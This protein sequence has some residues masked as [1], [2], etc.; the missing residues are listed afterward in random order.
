MEISKPETAFV[1][2]S[3]VLICIGT[4]LGGWA[5]S[6]GHIALLLS[7]GLMLFRR[8]KLPESNRG[9][10][11]VSIGLVRGSM[12]FL[13]VICALDILTIVLFYDHYP[14]PLKDLK[15]IR[16]LLIPLGFL[17][18]TY[19]RDLGRQYLSKFGVLG[20]WLIGGAV[21]LA[22]AS[23][24]IGYYT[25][26][27]PLRFGAE[28]ANFDRLSGIHGMVMTY[29]YSLQFVVLLF[30][31]VLFLGWRKLN[32]Y[33]LVFVAVT[34]GVGVLGL[35][36]SMTRGA[37]L[38]LII[39][40]VALVFAAK[41]WKLIGVGVVALLL[42]L[43]IAKETRFVV[44]QSVSDSARL[45]Q[46][47]ASAI[48]FLD[49]PL[50]GVGYRQLEKNMI[51]FKESYDL[52]LDGYR[53]DSGD[54]IDGPR[55]GGHAHNNFLEAFASTGVFGGLAFV[56]FSVSWLCEVWRRRRTRLLFFPVVVA[57]VVSG[58]FQCTFIDGEVLTMLMLLYVASQIALD[59]ESS[60]L[61][62]V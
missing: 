25:G 7:F 33:L 22:T 15:K 56:G 60:P 35:Y 57:F 17:V 30:L 44:P 31:G 40:C 34:I 55:L 46:W 19:S 39:G 45:S 53:Y 49:N 27:N 28:T 37:V 9:K 52:P 18:F 50:F 48:I 26:Y 51:S 11:T 59:R 5:I 8:W 42:A 47:R 24:F 61:S 2:I 54:F 14:H 10:V 29:A 41:A 13:M 6:T 1:V 32:I 4:F 36:F 23:G 58:C 21:I 20:L 43:L 16:Y 3:F 12:W 62:T 38:G